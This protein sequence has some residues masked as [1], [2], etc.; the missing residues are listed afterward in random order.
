MSSSPSPKPSLP[1]S[2]DLNSLSI[3]SLFGV[4][5]RIAGPYGLIGGAFGDSDFGWEH[6]RAVVEKSGECFPQIIEAALPVIVLAWPNKI[7]LEGCHVLFFAATTHVLGV[8]GRC[9]EF[10]VL[11]GL[12]LESRK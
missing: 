6:C 3:I 11:G 5:G 12:E 8:D 7:P 10:A 4:W 1:S 9:A 2:T